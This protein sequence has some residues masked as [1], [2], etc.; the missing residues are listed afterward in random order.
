M[1]LE[2]RRYAETRQITSDEA[3]VRLLEAGL[4]AEEEQLTDASE[5]AGGVDVYEFLRQLRSARTEPEP[6]SA[7][8]FFREI[9]ETKGFSSKAEAHRH[10][11]ALR[12][13]WR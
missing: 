10:I 7:T 11:Q 4:T 1:E 13:E 3:L 12:D 2:I 9:P 5:P 8:E 6:I